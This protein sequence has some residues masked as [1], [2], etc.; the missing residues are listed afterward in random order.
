MHG[1]TAYH[2]EGRCTLRPSSLTLALRSF[3][4]AQPWLAESAADR[5]FGIQ[6]Q[7][8]AGREKA[9]LMSAI[10]VEAQE[11]RPAKIAMSRQ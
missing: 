9:A 11:S 4:S 8:Q 5:L 2:T 10:F 7:H 6:A 1:M 3:P